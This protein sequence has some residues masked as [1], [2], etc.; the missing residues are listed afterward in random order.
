MVLFHKDPYPF[1]L[2]DDVK[3]VCAHLR[4]RKHWRKL[5]KGIID[6]ILDNSSNPMFADIGSADVTKM[7]ILIS[8]ERDL[9][10]NNFL[11]IAR[12]GGDVDWIVGLFSMT[13]YRLGSALLST[14]SS[15]EDEDSTSGFAEFA[16]MAFISS[17]LCYPRNLASM[18]GL[19]QLW[20]HVFRNKSRSLN[21]C[22]R[23]KDT[24]HRLANSPA[25]QLNLW[26]KSQAAILDPREAERVG[27]AISEC[28]PALA[29]VTPNGYTLGEMTSGV[30]AIEAF[31]LQQPDA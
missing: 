26:D 7:L 15:A 16:D 6:H 24:L 1:E 11:P 10:R 20:F 23:Y 14:W 31:L 12:K 13:L 5:D 9:L 19:A 29:A 18:A 21:W 8:E 30:E 25:E 3:S 22:Q 17:L 27:H 28:L 4:Q 2:P